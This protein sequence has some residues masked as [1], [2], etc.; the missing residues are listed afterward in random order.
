[1]GGLEALPKAP[2]LGYELRPAG[3]KGVSSSVETQQ[4]QVMHNYCVPLCT[5]CLEGWH[6]QPPEGSWGR[7]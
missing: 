3:F 5:S 2:P 6:S 4:Q 1:M 7:G